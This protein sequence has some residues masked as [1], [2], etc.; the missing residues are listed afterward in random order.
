MHQSISHFCATLLLD[1]YN[2]FPAVDSNVLFQGAADLHL[3]DVMDAIRASYCLSF[4]DIVLMVGGNDLQMDKA[5]AQYYYMQMFT[6]IAKRQPQAV[7]WF[8]TLRPK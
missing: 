7:I 4:S 5:W 8:C 1:H 6:D 3:H 2:N